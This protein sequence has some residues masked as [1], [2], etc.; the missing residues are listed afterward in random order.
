MNWNK[1]KQQRIMHNAYC[2]GGV[3]SLTTE[4]SRTINASFKEDKPKKEVHSFNSY[5]KIY[6]KKLSEIVGAG[7]NPKI[8]PCSKTCHIK[9]NRVEFWPKTG[10]WYCPNTK[11]KGS[12]VDSFISHLIFTRRLE[13]AKK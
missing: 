7:F 5:Y 6:K 2:R 4:A 12:G 8:M 3:T 11:T 9:V 10:K 1:C 13:N